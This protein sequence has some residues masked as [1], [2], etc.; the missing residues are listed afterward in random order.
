MN[1]FAI[2]PRRFRAALAIIVMAGVTVGGLAGS[3]YAL[4]RN[5]SGLLNKV[6]YD[7]GKANY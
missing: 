5:C 7:Y 6:N 2:M 4:P 1:T 3:A